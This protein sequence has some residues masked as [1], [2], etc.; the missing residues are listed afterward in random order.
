MQY[1]LSAHAPHS[2]LIVGS[3]ESL[4]ISPR[5]NTDGLV[6]GMC[7]SKKNENCHCLT[8]MLFQTCLHF[9]LL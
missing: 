8:L 4:D 7:P 6:K 2:S 1:L 3:L 5:D 9:F